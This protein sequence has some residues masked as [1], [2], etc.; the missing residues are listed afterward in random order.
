MKSMF[1]III[2]MFSLSSKVDGYFWDALFIRTVASP[3]ETCDKKEKDNVTQDYH[4][5]NKTQLETH[6]ILE[7]K[8]NQTDTNELEDAQEKYIRIMQLEEVIRKAIGLPR[9]SNKTDSW[10]LPRALETELLSIGPNKAKRNMESGESKKVRHYA[11][12]GVPCKCLLSVRNSFRC[13]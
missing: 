4:A 6:A 7:N 12:Y 2:V 3:N 9:P 10:N 8:T 1:L 5:D 13:T 11:V